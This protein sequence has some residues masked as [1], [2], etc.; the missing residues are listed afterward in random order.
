MRFH[1]LNLFLP[2]RS[3]RRLV[4]MLAAGAD[5]GMIGPLDLNTAKDLT[6]TMYGFADWKALGASLRTSIPS[7]SD[8][9]LYDLDELAARRRWQAAELHRRYPAMLPAFAARF[10]DAWRPTCGIAIFHPEHATHGDPA[11]LDARR[12]G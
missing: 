7:E 11:P 9:V 10:I 12:N 4:E 8:E 1:I 5:G 3:A 2:R 6:A